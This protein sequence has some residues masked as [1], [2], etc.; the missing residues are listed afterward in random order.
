MTGDRLARRIAAMTQSLRALERPEASD[1]SRLASDPVLRAAV[2]RWIQVAVEGAID[3]T[4]HVAAREGWTPPTTA[5]ATFLTLAGH[6]VIPV[7]LATRLG[8][9]AALRN[10]LVHDYAEL[11][12]V[13]LATI[14]RDDLGD[15]RALARALAPWIDR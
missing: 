5:R 9:A 11:D 4:Q 8:R 7:E 10:L 6:G 1:A 15:L 13:R 12:L 14:V 2:E 3:A